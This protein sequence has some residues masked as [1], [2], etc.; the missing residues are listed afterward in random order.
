MQQHLEFSI[1]QRL[2]RTPDPLGRLAPRLG[3]PH[4]VASSRSRKIF[5]WSSRYL[6]GARLGKNIAHVTACLVLDYP[7]RVFNPT[8]RTGA[9]TQ[10]ILGSLE[11]SSHASCQVVFMG[12]G[13]NAHAGAY[14]K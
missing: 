1:G 13:D 14:P 6:D 10:E 7:G 5:A 2:M 8:Q 3:L 9:M 11:P 4:L 12:V